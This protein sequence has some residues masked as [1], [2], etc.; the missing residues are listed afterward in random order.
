MYCLWGMTALM[1]VASGRFKLS[2]LFTWFLFIGVVIA[3]SIAHPFAVVYDLSVI[4]C[5][6]LFC[7]LVKGCQVNYRSI[8]KCLAVCGFFV[9][10]CVV[11]DTSTGLFRTQLID[12][13]TNWAKSTKL[14]LQRSGGILPQTGSAGGY[15]YSGA[16]AYI[17]HRSINGK[18]LKSVGCWITIAMFGLSALM[19]GKRG[20][21]LDSVL[22]ILFI[23]AIQLRKQDISRFKIRRL[24]QG[25]AWM[26]LIALA[27]MTLYWQVDIVRESV[28]QLIEKFASEDGSYSGRTDLYMFAFT[29]FRGH[30]L[31]GIGWGQFRK[32]STG[33]FGIADATYAAHNVYIQLLCETGILG[34]C[35]FLIAAASSLAYAVKKY[36]NMVHTGSTGPGKAVM[37]LGF[38]LQMFFL[39]Y[40]MHGN[41][42]Y[43]Y[44]FCITYFIGILLTV[45][46]V[47]ERAGKTGIR[48]GL[49]RFE[50]L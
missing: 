30:Y 37:E 19:I 45:I 50:R 21:I 2:F 4:L 3:E 36:R 7:I 5:G 10:L 35:V 12:L 26:L 38:F 40:C 6:A 29:L 25:A 22:A 20:F 23:Q 11:L 15:I 33:F 34:L 31:K 17:T 42:L 24:L 49:P 1:V 41:P 13:Y 43:D 8:V 28:D 46:T 27:A 16:A 47:P 48:K 14:S 18:S 32:K 9:S 44:N 39:A